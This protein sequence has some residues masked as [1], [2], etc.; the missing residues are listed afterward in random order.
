MTRNNGT[1]VDRTVAIVL[2]GGKGT[3]LDPLTRSVCKPALPFGGAFRCIDFSLSNCVNSGVRRIGVATQYE[4]DALLAHLWSHWN[5]A[6][7]GDDAVIHAWRAE[8]RA[9]RFGYCGTADAVYRN[10]ASIRELTD[11]LVLVLAGDHVYKMDYRPMLEAHCARGAAVTIGCIDAPIEDARHFGVLAASEDGRIEHFVEKPRCLAEMWNT[12]TDS[13]LASMGIYV[14]DGAFLAR[15]LHIDAA[16]PDSG[17]DFGADILP[18][19]IEGGRA[20][21]YPFR[22][23]DGAAAYWR[24]IGTLEAYW[25][26]H[27]E[28][29]G[30]KP[31]LRL[32]DPRWPVGRMAAAPKSISGSVTTAAGGVVENSIATG[33]CRIAGQVLRCVL[34][35]DVD[36][37]RAAKIT[38]SVVLPGAVIGA[39]SRLQ[40]VIVDGG[41][42]V[43]EGTVIERFAG[44]GDPPVL[45]RHY[46]AE[47]AGVANAR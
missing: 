8:E 36:V 45:S 39:G 16:H 44:I 23:T 4:P 24:D 6:A 35:D 34:F 17:H 14:F 47:A 31:R 28:L 40:G 2:A 46:T 1:V 43:P 5:R 32:D 20:Y 12:T 10:L 3:R 11:S 29:L 33:K 7:V 22:G 9:A 30:P 26:A 41:Y 42:R 37:G 21:S 15:I 18:R 25:R 19:L 13:V 38:E 27:M